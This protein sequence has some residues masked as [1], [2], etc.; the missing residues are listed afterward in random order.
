MSRAL[1]VLCNDAFRAKAVDWIMKAKKDTRVIFMGPQRTLDQNSRMWAMLTDIAT[2][3]LHFG[4]RYHADAWKVIFLSALGRETQF[5]PALDG[6]G[7]IPYGQ[8][9]SEL[10][11]EEMSGMIELM[12]AW[13]EENGVVF[14]EP[15]NLRENAGRAA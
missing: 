6:V 13:G 15:G 8:S 1:L 11:K 10:S 9:S 4:R 2:Q 14:H 5:I 3:K 7:F 12:F